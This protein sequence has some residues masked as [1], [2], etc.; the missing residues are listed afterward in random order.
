M[1]FL[2]DGKVSLVFG[3]HTHIQ[4]NDDQVLPKGTGMISDI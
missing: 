2:L 4:T 1:S 3:T